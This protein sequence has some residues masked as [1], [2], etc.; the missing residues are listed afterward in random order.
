[1]L[2]RFIIV[3]CVLVCVGVLSFYAVMVRGLYIDLREEV[4][5][6]FLSR[7]N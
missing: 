2:K 3:I 4:A 6:A 1:M 5:V 7:F